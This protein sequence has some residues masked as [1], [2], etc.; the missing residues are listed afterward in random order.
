MSCLM[1]ALETYLVKANTRKGIVA[2]S[3]PSSTLRPE[4]QRNDASNYTDFD[5]SKEGLKCAATELKLH[6][7][8]AQRTVRPAGAEGQ[9]RVEVDT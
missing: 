1:A 2:D 4:L 3:R 5:V 8:A 6:V 9:E 7:G